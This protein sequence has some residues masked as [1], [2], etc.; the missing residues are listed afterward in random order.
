MVHHT[1]AKCALLAS[2]FVNMDKEN[3][4]KEKSVFI[5]SVYTGYHESSALIYCW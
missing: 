1:C 4:E 5:L 2:I 3:A